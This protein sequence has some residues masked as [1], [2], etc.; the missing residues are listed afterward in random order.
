MMR[1]RVIWIARRAASA[2]MKRAVCSGVL[3]LNSKVSLSQSRHRLL[4][5]GLQAMEWTRHILI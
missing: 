1:L 5:N 2:T 4:L 3:P